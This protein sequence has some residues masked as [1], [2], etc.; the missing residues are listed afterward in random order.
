M[1]NTLRSGDTIIVLRLD[2]LSKIPGADRCLERIIGTGSIV[3]VRDPVAPSR[4]VVKRIVA[5]GGDTILV[6]DRGLIVN[7]QRHLEPSSIKQSAMASVVGRRSITHIPADHYFLLADNRMAGV[8][9][10]QYGAV[11]RDSIIGMTLLVLQTAKGHSMSDSS[12]IV[13]IVVEEKR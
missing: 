11:H 6:D 8:D 1:E 7:G 4:V 5:R 12:P 3:I 10:R 13:P 2:V 9:S